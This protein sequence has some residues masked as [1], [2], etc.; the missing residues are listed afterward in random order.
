MD[1]NVKKLMVEIPGLGTNGDKH[2]YLQLFA[3]VAISIRDVG[4]PAKEVIRNGAQ[5]PAA[6]TVGLLTEVLAIVGLSA[7][8]K[9]KTYIDRLNTNQ[10][11]LP[12]WFSN[13]L[14]PFFWLR[15]LEFDHRRVERL[16]GPCPTD[17]AT[18]QTA[19]IWQ[20]W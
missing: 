13:L 1:D 7:L 9:T 14:P 18:L 19:H 20:H 16:R 10:P 5:H 17:P 2:K 15:S 3:A 12:L 4:V 6:F 8:A 11:S